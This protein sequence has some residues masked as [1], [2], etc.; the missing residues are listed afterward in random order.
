M[1][2]QCWGKSGILAYFVLTIGYFGHIFRDMDFKFV[3]PFIYI[4]GAR[5]GV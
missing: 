2:I 1:P 4:K 3:L 5:D